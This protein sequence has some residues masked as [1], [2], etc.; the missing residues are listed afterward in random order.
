MQRRI[1]W[2]Y[3]GHVRQARLCEKKRNKYKSHIVLRCWHAL[4]VSDEQNNGLSPSP[5]VT[6]SLADLSAGVRIAGLVV[7]LFA[8]SA[9]RSLQNVS[10]PCVLRSLCGDMTRNPAPCG[11]NDPFAVVMVRG[12]AGLMSTSTLAAN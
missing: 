6:V 11:G 10:Q 4:F 3:A 5:L 7:Q 12:R 8:G 2:G 9:V 1:L